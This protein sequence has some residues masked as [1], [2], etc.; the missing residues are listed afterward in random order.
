MLIY[1]A[2][3]GKLFTAIVMQI[4]WS[5]SGIPGQQTSPFQFTQTVY[6]TTIYENSAAKSYVEC[7]IKMGIYITDP[8]WDIQ[9]KIESGDGE[10]LFK[11][12][13]YVLGDFSFLRIRTKGGSSAILNREVKEHYSLIVKALKWSTNAVAQTRVQVRVLDTNDLRPLFSPTSYT[14]SVPEHADIRTSIVRVT[15]TDADVGSNAEYYFS[16]GGEHTHM[17]AIHPTSGVITLMA[18][19]DYAKRR[20]FEMDVLAVDRGMKLYGSSGFSSTAKL[21]VRVLQANDHAPVLT[22]VPLAPSATDTDPTYALVT[23]EDNDQGPNGEIASLSIVAG[24]PLQQFRAVKTSPGGKE[25][26]V[27][28][29]K[30]VDW[31]SCQFGC[32]LTLQAEDKGSPPQFSSAEVIR[33]RPPR[34]DVRAPTFEKNIYRV[35]LTEFS[36][37][38]TSVVMVRAM[39]NHPMLK[40]SIKYPKIQQITHPFTINSNTGLITTTAAIQAD[41]ASKYDF[42]VI[43]NNQEQASTRVVINVIDVNNNAPVFQQPTYKGNVNENVPVGTSILTVSASDMDEGENGYV[44]YT[45]ANV[46]PPQPFT[47]D[48]FT[49]VISTARELDYEKMPRVYNLR[50]RASDWGSPFRR[51]VE[52]PVSITLNNLNDNEPLFEKVDCEVSLPRYYRVGEQIVAVSAIDADD[53]EGV[54]HVVIDGNSLG[55]FDLT[56]DTGLLSL[57]LPL[58]DGEAA[59]LSFHSLQISAN[60]GETS[61]KPMFVNITVLSGSGAVFE[62]CVDTG[63]VGRMAEKLLLGTMPPSQREDHFEDIH[64]INNYFPHF[65][66]S[67]PKVIE[68]KEDLQVGMRIAHLSAIDA[69]HGF[70]GTLMFVISGGDV[71]SRFMIEM[72]TGWLKIMEPLDREIIDQYTLNITVY[73]LGT[74]QRSASHV[75]QINVLDSNDNSPNFLQNSYSV[76]IRE[77]TDVG[78]AVIQ[79]DATDKDSGANRIIRYSLMAESDHFV[80]DDQTGVVKVKSPLDRELHPTIILKVVARDQA[81][82]EPQMVS[83]VS[84]K[85]VLEDINDNP[86]RFFPLH[87]RVKVREDLPLGAVVVW[88]QAHDPDQGQS[89]QVRFS[90]LDNGDGDFDVDKTNGAVRILRT[91]DFER[92]QVYNLTARAK[93]KGKPESLSCTCFIE[94][95]VVDVDENLH[96]PRFASFVD[97]GSVRE[98]APIGTTIMTVIAQDNDQ[99]RAGEI[100]YSI[101]DGSGLGV[102]TIDEE[103]G[104]RFLLFKMITFKP[105]PAIALKCTIYCML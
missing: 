18:R 27:K 30:D 50:V 10:V 96:Q 21:T 52:T 101:R 23:V 86:P 55:L 35:N 99:G 62:K 90:L 95:Y 78:T 91:L 66:D 48:Y 31:D 73:D 80:I 97:K 38:N 102:F 58:H 5:C 9:Y 82:D 75:L 8:S 41:C 13:E 33:V 40:Y 26:R 47:I 1:D 19:L 93:D 105:N 2:N 98:D 77:D 34:V 79:V 20:L 88:L 39:P 28:A 24:D 85:I 76:S 25:Y 84:L 65:V 14:V 32:N 44:T 68:V 56:P 6:N 7:P 61:S 64:S 49:G 43:I 89:G 4:L 54:Q 11:A 12:E 69:D 29:I 67:T 53:M 72:D 37:P 94:V 15:A 42:E 3:M 83:T 51:E 87:Q 71:E 74:P 46:N 17:F 57:K 103:S 16:L 63:V 104:K 22:A 92:R 45:I 59:R 70:S 81:V 36:P 100:R 60:D